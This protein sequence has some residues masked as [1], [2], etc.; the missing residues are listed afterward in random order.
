M[1]RSSYVSANSFKFLVPLNFNANLIYYF[2]KEVEITMFHEF[3]Y[4]M[5]DKI[6]PISKT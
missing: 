5:K 1:N 4:Q 3:F 6:N 2:I